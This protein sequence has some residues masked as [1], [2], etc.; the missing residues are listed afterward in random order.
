MEGN[1]APQ[2]P[3]HTEIVDVHL[4]LRRDEEVLLSRRHRTGCADGLLHAPSGHVEDGEDV[5]AAVIREAAEEIGV[6][7]APDRKVVL[8]A[9]GRSG[10]GS[11]RG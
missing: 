9:S 2:R 4:I 8:P 3:R 6:T 1:L 7:L 11:A 10:H 5:R